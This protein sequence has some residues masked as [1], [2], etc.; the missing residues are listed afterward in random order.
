MSPENQT[1]TFEQ[2][3]RAT[4]PQV[5]HAFTNATALREWLCDSA[6]AIPHPGGRLYMWWNSG[7]YAA[8]E[9]LI[10]R[11]NELVSFS[12]FG[13]G[14]PGITQVE[15]TLNTRDDS[16]VVTLKHSGLGSGEEWAHA[17]QE[18]QDGWKRGLEN[19]ASVL[20][21]GQD[22]RFVLRPMLGITIGEFNAEEA[23][24]LGLPISEGVRLDG[25]VDG[26]GAQAAGLQA[27]DVIISLDGKPAT[28]WTSLTNALQAHR[29]G[30]KV[31]VMFYRGAEK[32]SIPM[33]LSRRP[34]PD[35]PMNPSGLAQAVRQRYAESDARLREFFKGVTEE[36]ASYKPGP[37]EWSAK[38]VLA[39]FIHGERYTGNWIEELI[40]GQERWAD[41]WAGNLHERVR[42]TV[43][44]YPTV[45]DLLQELERTEMET[46][47]L[48]ADLPAYFVAR[49]G[50][51]WRLA[52][53]L[54]EDPYHLN[55]HLEQMQASIEAARN[56]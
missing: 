4:A 34:M 6:Q 10:T 43:K 14:D 3:I 23:K 49:K 35:I 30:D 20:E 27:G 32:R 31:E 47:S 55:Q 45:P 26:M 1:Q 25:V 7:Y 36:Q 41:D 8:G 46:V 52:H 19:L 33:V 50:S 51:Y 21:T 29:A 22:L 28:D 42:A 37:Q 40:A 54:L 9:Y 39:H 53:S 16:T 48:L 11:P 12:W 5:Y 13:R 44:A 17:I 38:E 56:K 24:R 2:T 15:V 18:I